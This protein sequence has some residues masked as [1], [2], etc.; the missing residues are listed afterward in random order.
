MD[1]KIFVFLGFILAAFVLMLISFLSPSYVLA[2]PIRIIIL[3]L[4][5]GLD[6][7]AFAS[8]YYAYLILPIV[9]QHRRNIVLSKEEPYFLASSGDSI[10][11]RVGEEFTATVY[12][13]IPYYRS[14]TEMTPEE[15]LEFTKQVSRLIGI[16]S[17]PVRFT[18]Q[19]HVMNKDAYLQTLRDVINLSENEETQLMATENPPPGKIDRVR[20]KLSMWHNMLDNV[21]KTV[22]LEL[23]NYAAVS[24]VGSKEFEAT[25][26]AQQRAREVISGIAATFGITPT[27]VTGEAILKF[28]EPEYLIPY[29]TITEQISK[30]IS[31]QVS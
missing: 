24:A 3:L 23:V 25:T 11:R 10:I 26:L 1:K 15:K 16:S 29:S 8:R 4:A 14:A 17:S 31:E 13:K 9:L 28:V 20:G 19:M 22:A 5:F 12:I 27:I 21:S 2:A 30:T 7:V 18:A 6:V